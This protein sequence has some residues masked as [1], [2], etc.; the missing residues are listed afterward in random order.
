MIHHLSIAAQN[1]KHV[2]HVLAELLQG[3][4]VPFPD[5]NYPDSFVALAFDTCGTTV[6]KI[7]F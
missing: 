5:G 6:D 3:S 7:T 1:P 2:A 4:A